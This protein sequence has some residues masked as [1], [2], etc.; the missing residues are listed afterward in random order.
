MALAAECTDKGCIAGVAGCFGIAITGIE[1]DL[2]V[3]AA[4][5]DF[6]CVGGDGGGGRGALV[7]HSGATPV[8]HDGTFISSKVLLVMQGDTH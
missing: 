8:K 1:V 7:K 2:S 6:F 4:G 5:E 3:A